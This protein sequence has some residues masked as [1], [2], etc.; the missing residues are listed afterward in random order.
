MKKA[1]GLVVAILIFLSCF[2]FAFT[3]YVGQSKNEIIA[4]L[5]NPN[6]EDISADMSQGKVERCQWGSE[7]AGGMVV[8]WFR[9]GKVIRFETKGK[10]R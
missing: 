2:S 8:I 10:V 9:N 7:R 3:L 4:A 5:G 1:F 6:Y